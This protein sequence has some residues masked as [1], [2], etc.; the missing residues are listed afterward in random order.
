MKSRPSVD[1]KRTFMSN[2]TKWLSGTAF[3]AW[4]CDYLTR[5]ESLLSL[6]ILR[7]DIFWRYNIFEYFFSLSYLKSVCSLAKFQ[8]SRSSKHG[9]TSSYI[10]ANTVIFVAPN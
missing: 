8:D 5:F 2:P 6:R 9:V 3:L 7:D 10:I 4:I 1:A